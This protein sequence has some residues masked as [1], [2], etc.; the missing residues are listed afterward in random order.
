LGYSEKNVFVLVEPGAMPTANAVII[1]DHMI[2]KL[3]RQL[4]Q[5]FV[6]KSQKA[7]LCFFSC[8]SR[9]AMNNPAGDIQSG[10]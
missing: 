3:K 9:L 8:W 2:L 7:F 6:H 1:H 4:R 10:K 5:Q